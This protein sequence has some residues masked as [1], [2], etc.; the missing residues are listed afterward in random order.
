MFSA[1]CKAE[2]GGKG[3]LGG[4]GNQTLWKDSS[5]AGLID[6]FAKRKGVKPLEAVGDVWKVSKAYPE[7]EAS[8]AAS[9]PE[10]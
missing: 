10:P 7:V 6:L 2:K 1:Q 5:F 8:T 4:G 3:G 9:T